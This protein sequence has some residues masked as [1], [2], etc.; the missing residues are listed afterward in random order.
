M[1][2]GG[3]MR[4]EQ[5]TDIAFISF[6][7]L[8]C[9]SPVISGPYNNYMVFNNGLH[10]MLGLVDPYPSEWVESANFRNWYLYSP[11]FGLFFLLFSTSGVGMHAGIY[12]WAMLNLFFFWFGFKSILNILDEKDAL[13][14]GWV[15]FFALL[16]VVNEFMGTLTN[17]QS[18]AFIIGLSL[19]GISWYVKGR[20]SLSAF[21]LAVGFNFKLFP[22]AVALLL[23][24]DFKPRFAVSFILFSTVIFAIPLAIL[25]ADFYFG[26][27]GHWMQIMLT[28]PVHPV[29]LGLEPTLW[30]YGY[31]PDSSWFGTFMLANALGIAAIAFLA[32][33]KSP[34]RFVETV[35]PLILLFII[36][37][38]KR[39]EKPS[40]IIAVPVM[41]F[42]LH[43]AI[44]S[45]LK[46]NSTLAY[47]HF[48]VLAFAWFLISYFFSDLCPKAFRNVADEKHFKTLGAL[49]LYVWAW[50]RATWSFEGGSQKK[51]SLPSG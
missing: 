40:F 7:M 44:N 20:Y 29:F 36:L 47:I 24:M 37:F 34:E 17:S 4:F 49:L 14:R 46:G 42:V 51:L 11:T 16:L 32:F 43:S 50:W 10:S 9:I 3:I 33:R 23:I 19:L 2:E 1:V 21:A 27:L 30:S 28:D 41:T 39:S 26:I 5:K 35:V 6:F 25:P 38:N 15:Y 31:R 48:A 18:N 22:L 12:L 45:R 13:F 8:L